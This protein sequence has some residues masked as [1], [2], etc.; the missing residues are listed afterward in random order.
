MMRNKAK[1]R[2][3]AGT[4]VLDGNHNVAVVHMPNPSYAMERQMVISRQH[5]GPYTLDELEENYDYNGSCACTP[6]KFFLFM[7]LVGGLVVA[8][9]YAEGVIDPGA[10]SSGSIP[11]DNNGDSGS[12]NGDNNNNGNIDTGSG[13]N[14]PATFE[15]TLPSSLPV[16]SRKAGTCDPTSCVVRNRFRFDAALSHI[17][18]YIFEY[19]IYFC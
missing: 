1:R 9:L 16:E 12:S 17:H 14:I 19:I 18:C 2:E 11:N 13:G 10:S 4:G 3:L 7:L 15:D 6:F 8:G 5:G